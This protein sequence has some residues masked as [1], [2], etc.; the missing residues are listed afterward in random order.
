MIASNSNSLCK[1]AEPY[2]Y[3]FLTG[4]SCEAVPQP[5]VEHIEQCG[6][7]Q[8]QL[9]RLGK[10]L[11]E[12]QGLETEQRQVRNIVINMLK[13][14]LTYIG[15][16]VTCGRAKPFL[17]GLLD[18]ILKIRIPTPIT[19]HVD[20][21]PQCR[22]DLETI[23]QLNLGRKQLWRLAQFLSDRPDE[24]AVSCSQARYAVPLVAALDWSSASAE[25]LK[26][27]CK[28]PN[29]R[30]LV[31]RERQKILDSLPEYD[32]SPEFPCDLVCAADIF[33]Y[34]FPCGIDPAEDQY[35][36]FRES[37]TP[38]L[39]DCRVCLSKIQEL[40]KTIY[41]ITERPE[42]GIVT[43][44]HID[45]SA[46]DEVF[47]EG[48]ELYAGFPIRVEVTG[49]EEKADEDLL[50]LPT[51]FAPV[52]REKI[53]MK[54]YK[55]RLKTVIAAAAV[56]LI[57]V[58]LFLNTKTAKAVTL[59][60]IYNAIEKV[61]NV[62]IAKFALDKTEP[63]QELWISKTLNICMIKI[64]NEAVL[65]NIPGR[66]KKIKHYDT[67]TVRMTQLAEETLAA[68][69]KQMGGFLGIVPFYDTSEIPPD[70]EWH[71]VDNDSFA[72]T[73]EGIEVYELKYVKK[74]HEGYLIVYKWRFFIDIKTNLPRRT[75]LYQKL[76]ADD[77]EYILKTVNKIQYLSDNEIQAVLREMSF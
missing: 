33:D 75:E 22:G 60:Q 24:V 77:N 17:P 4:E 23:Q 36:K 26:H 53:S 58:G 18:A 76:P 43:I 57:A 50:T 72:V 27:L 10:V 34:C 61:K 42:S 49:S 40:H 8:K 39:L 70:A 29:C 12:V 15:K 45:E 47:G 21:C 62:Y 32:Q 2:Y 59:E 66:T 56:I 41:E 30:N 52:L 73:A 3:D 1:Q 69:E 7:C 5:I 44:Y 20:N 16:R 11:S 38:H 19:A 68:V 71:H 28:C 63:I 35:A 48:N 9:D 51:D 14:H 31:Y 67:G 37:L 54:N 6:Y 13:F 46:K 65:W 55:P 25:V 74:T 64:G